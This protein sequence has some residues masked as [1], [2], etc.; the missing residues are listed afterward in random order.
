M[1]KIY[2]IGHKNPDTDTIISAILMSEFLNLREDTK[3]YIPVISGK[4]NS[5]TEFVFNKFGIKF[6][7]ILDDASDQK[8]YLVD[9]NEE[10]QYVKGASVENV[11]GILDHHKMNFKNYLPIEI[12]VKPWG[13]SNTVVYDLFQKHNMQIPSELKPLVLCAL[14]SDTVILKSPTTT[15]N[16]VKLVENLSKELK[17]DYKKLGTEMFKAKSKVAEKS[18]E[19]I[20]YN[21][22]KDFDFGEKKVGVGQVETPDLSEI[23]KRAPEI[24]QK[25]QEI[26]NK[27]K[28]H[29]LLL[30][31]TDIINEGSKLLIV[32]DAT[33]SIAKLFNVSVKN[34]MTDFIPGIMSRKKQVVS[35][36]EKL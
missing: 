1:D 3:K 11:V 25:M 17:L 14:L 23:E 33:E 10:S 28:Y 12:T 20:I 9:H 6:P 18:A 21:D 26:K 24:R 35:V 22:F 7:K 19:K 16:E 31:L 32:S 34:G 2:V 15:E 27:G 8:L 29:S 13:S 36:L 4:P 5:E 30:M